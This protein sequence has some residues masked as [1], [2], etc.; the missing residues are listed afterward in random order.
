MNIIFAHMNYIVRTNLLIFIFF[1]TQLKAISEW[2]CQM[3]VV[4]MNN[5][6]KDISQLSLDQRGEKLNSIEKDINDILSICEPQYVNEDFDLDGADWWGLK[7]IEQKVNELYA[8]SNSRNIVGLTQKVIYTLN[9]E[10]KISGKVIQ[11][12]SFGPP[13]YGETPQYDEKITS[14]VLQLK[15]PITVE[16]FDNEKVETS[17][18]QL[19][20]HDFKQVQYALKNDLS[21]SVEGELFSSD[22]GYH[23]RKFLLDVKN[24]NLIQDATVLSPKVADTENIV[25]KTE[26]SNTKLNTSG[27]SEIS[28]GNGGVLTIGNR[29]LVLD[30]IIIFSF[31]GMIVITM[32]MGVGENRKIVI[33]QDY[34]DVG[35]TF[36]V[37]V[38]FVLLMML[39]PSVG[40]EPKNAV[41]FA[42]LVSGIL[43]LILVRNTY[44]YNNGSILYTFLALITKVPLGVLWIIALLSTLN[45]SGNTAKKRRQSRA[46]ALILLT[47][48]TPL[49]MAFIAEKRGSLLNPKDW[50]RYKRVGNLRDQL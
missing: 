32:M 2:N 47:L 20:L 23:I 43:L 44:R 36:V 42:M 9:S 13:G 39:A 40:G 14:Y 46:Q 12:Q 18:I 10:Y 45:P 35:L 26:V 31:F 17:E 29:A 49:I 5:N 38:S 21:I 27:D 30:E 50:L 4:E 41:I 34:D 6:L 24:I 25:E 3:M 19:V 7:S 15:D 1:T 28:E 16:N 33:F 48:L 11:V 22:T 37:P 8:A